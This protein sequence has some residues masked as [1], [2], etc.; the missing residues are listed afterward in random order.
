MAE[1]LRRDILQSLA[2]T[3]VYGCIMFMLVGTYTARAEKL[4]D[5]RITD[6]SGRSVTLSEEEL[7]KLPRS[8]IKTQTAWTEGVHH[9][10][11]ATLTD[12]LKKA[13]IDVSTFSPE[14][15]LRLTAWND[16]IVDIPLSDATNYNTLI[17]A[18]MDG[19]RLTIKDKGPYWLVYPRDDHNELQDSRFDHRWSWQLKELTIK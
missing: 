3:V 5:L 4:G 13:N 12:V 1:V 14:T 9:F 19:T 6:S 7:L 11:G 15:L 16:Y 8:S 17:A 18:F 2:L 10:E